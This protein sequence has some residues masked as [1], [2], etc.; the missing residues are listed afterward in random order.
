V[1]FRSNR[2]DAARPSA[3]S[4][5]RRG[6]TRVAPDAAPHAVNR[7]KARRFIAGHDSRWRVETDW[8]GGQLTQQGVPPDEHEW[9]ESFGCTRWYREF[10]TGVRDY[11][12]RYYPLTDAARARAELNPG[13]GA[14]SRLCHEPRRSGRATSTAPG[15]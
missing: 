13:D 1:L 4:R 12:R 9:I 6:R 10:R 7:R 5:S 3:A 2:R 14:V 11:Y 8:I 15:S